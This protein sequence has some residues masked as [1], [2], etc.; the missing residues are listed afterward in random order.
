MTADRTRNSKD[1]PLLMEASTVGVEL[2]A[3]ALKVRFE[4]MVRQ[5]ERGGITV[6]AD[7][8]SVSV[9]FVPT[10]SIRDGDDLRELGV[11][12]RVHNACGGSG[13]G[14]SDPITHGAKP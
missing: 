14:V 4:A 11:S 5:A 7:A 1:R 2:A 3:Y 12:A 9:R 10:A 6:V 8:D 13:S